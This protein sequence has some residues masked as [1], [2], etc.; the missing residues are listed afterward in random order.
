[1]NKKQMKK[2]WV[3]RCCRA[4]VYPDLASPKIAWYQGSDEVSP[5]I[6]YG[7]RCSKCHE[8]CEVI[9]LPKEEEESEDIN[10]N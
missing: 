5:Y 9:D 6:A 7:W 10:G 8:P 4:R 3:S 2:E 1:M